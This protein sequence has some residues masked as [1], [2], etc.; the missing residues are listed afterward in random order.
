MKV[1]WSPEK[2]IS[3]AP[4]ADDSQKRHTPGSVSFVPSV[5]GLM[6]AGEVIKD[7]ISDERKK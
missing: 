7:L 6:I 3:P 2:A 5:A 1:L 4:L